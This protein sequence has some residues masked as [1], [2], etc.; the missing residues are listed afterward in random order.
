MSSRLILLVVAA[1]VITAPTIKIPYWNSTGE[2]YR[3]LLFNRSS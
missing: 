2:V 1:A 3:Q